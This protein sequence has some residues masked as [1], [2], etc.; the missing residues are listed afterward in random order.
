MKVRAICVGTKESAWNKYIG[1][2]LKNRRNIDTRI[3]FITYAGL[4]AEEL[5]EIQK[6]VAE[7]VVFEKVVYQKASPAVAAN[8]GPGTFGLLYMVKDK[9]I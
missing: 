1:L 4:S 2:A 6:K 3:L 5:T 7:K 9:T 8:C